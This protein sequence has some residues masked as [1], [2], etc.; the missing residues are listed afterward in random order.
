MHIISTFYINNIHNDNDILIGV[1]W[2]TIQQQ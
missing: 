1:S 2:E